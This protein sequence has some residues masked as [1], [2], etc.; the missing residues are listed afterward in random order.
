MIL[1]RIFVLSKSRQHKIVLEDKT[2][3]G[4]NRDWS[5][6]K[7]CNQL[8]A[9]TFE[10]L[11][12]EKRAQRVCECASYLAFWQCI[13]NANHPKKLKIA[14]FCD[15]RLCPLCQRRRSFRQFAVAVKIAHELLR[16]KPT[17]Q[18]VLLT[19][20]VP[21]IEL[22][23]LGK[24]ITHLLESWHRLNQRAEVKRAIRG[25]LRTLEVSYNHQRNDWHPH[26]HAALVVPSNYF[27]GKGYIKQERWLEMWRESTRQPEITQVDIRKSNLIQ[28]E[29]VM[30]L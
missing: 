10:D 21:N 20:T 15:V 9:E 18:F 17:Y 23:S 13:S 4:R 12:Q 5:V 24:T 22:E 26:I 7:Q 29:K 30:T 19:L 25:Y 8:L 6:A 1:P 27:T 2:A 16:R 14:N 11:G 3:S 28:K